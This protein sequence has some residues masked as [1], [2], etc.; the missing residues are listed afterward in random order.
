MG[1][2]APFTPLRA[3]MHRG[4]L[5]RVAVKHRRA[6]WS[7]GALGARATM[8]APRNEC[9]GRMPSARSH[10]RWVGGLGDPPCTLRHPGTH[11]NHR[12]NLPRF[13]ARS[14]ALRIHSPNQADIP[15]NRWRFPSTRKP[16]G[17]SW[18]AS[19]RRGSMPRSLEL[20]FSAILR[21]LAE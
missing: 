1:S 9:N 12:A 13:S 11:P 4:P 5:G 16:A 20:R 21:D 10:G 17:G 19:Q 8:S 7:S 3:W 14:Q 2:A 18:R 15:T 6:P